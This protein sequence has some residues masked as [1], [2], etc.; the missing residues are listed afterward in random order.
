MSKSV[1][2]LDRLIGSKMRAA[3]LQMGMSQSELGQALGITFQQVQKYEKGTNRVSASRL[4]KIANLLGM[5]ISDF[6][7]GA[8]TAETT[9]AEGLAS[10]ATLSKGDFQMVQNLNNLQNVKF[11]TALRAL[12]TTVKNDMEGRSN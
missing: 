3:R 1:G 6:F 8:E 12:V 7:K 9:A 2:S 5:E 10:L 4:Y 11:K